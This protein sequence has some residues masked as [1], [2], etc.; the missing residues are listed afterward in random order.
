[1][2]ARRLIFVFVAVQAVLGLR[3]EAAPPLT[4]IYDTLY[5]ADG[6]PFTGS[7]TISWRSFTAADA[8]NIPANSMTVQVVGGLLRVRL[9][10]TTN[11]SAN[12]YYTARFNA[13]GKVQFTELW[14]VPP[15]NLALAV[16]DV[17]IQSASTTN[18]TLDSETA[19]QVQ[20]SDVIGLTEALT[21]RPTRSIAFQPNRAALIDATG[22]IASVSGSEGDCVHVDGTAG[23]CGAGG[24]SVG[25]VDMETPSGTVNGVNTI[26]V[27][28]QA[29]FPATSLHLF[30]NGILQKPSVDYVLSGNGVT[31]LAV[32]TPQA[33]DILSASYRTAGQ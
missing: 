4:Q 19:V 33:G 11:A 26:F 13:D 28:S 6:T 12:A 27:L 8:S 3:L 25:F 20:I 18:L 10:P 1:M 9:V 23:P 24:S 2:S 31:F 30:R 7:A 14:A 5:K 15:S 29:P 22:A 16:K 32:A 17:R 21:D